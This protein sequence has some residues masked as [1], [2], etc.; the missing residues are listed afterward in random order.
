MAIILIRYKILLY[1]FLEEVCETKGGYGCIFPFKYK[2]QTY[3]ACT[4][5]GNWPHHGTKTWC[6]Y[7]IYSDGN[8]AKYD[9][10]VGGKACEPS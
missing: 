4:T 8:M 3:N 1:P 5:A 7:K 9:F 2:G 6:A 10:C